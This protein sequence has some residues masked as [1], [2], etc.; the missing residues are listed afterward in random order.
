MKITDMF[1]SKDQ[2]LLNQIQRDCS[3]YISQAQAAHGWLYRG[4]KTF[5][6]V[7]MGTSPTARPAKDSDPQ[8]SKWFDDNL[9]QA[10]AVALRSNSI[11]TTGDSEHAAGYGHLYVVFPKNG[12]DYTWTNHKD[13]ILQPNDMFSNS[14]AWPHVQKIRQYMHD[15]LSKVPENINRIWVK[16]LTWN[17]AG[18]MMLKVI[19][20]F[21][22]LGL[23]EQFRPHWATPQS[24]EQF[25]R[26]YQ[27]QTNKT[28]GIAAAIASKH[29]VLVKGD[30]YALVAP[31]WASKIQKKWQVPVHTDTKL[32]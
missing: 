19:N 15:N 30:Y 11:F 14:Q 26:K 24:H 31:D 29:E 25:I 5:S 2:K 7:R 6:S 12:S 17:S 32:N 3:L 18:D 9:Q 8:V 10:G 23:P 4:S 28:A 20:D 16:L 22:Q 13:I 21:D 27:P 1:L